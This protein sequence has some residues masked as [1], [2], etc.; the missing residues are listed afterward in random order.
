MNNPRLRP[1]YFGAA[2]LVAVWLLAWGGFRIAQNSK[3]TAAKFSAYLRAVDLEKLHGAAREQALRELADKLNALIPEERRRARVDREMD[4][5]FQQMTE[6]EK[7]KFIESTMPTGF[8]QMLTSFEKLPEDK[9]KKVID[10]TLKRFEDIRK[11][12]LPPGE[13]TNRPPPMSKELQKKVVTVGLSSF[14]S[15]SSAQTKAELAPV[16]EEMQRL[17]ESGQLFRRR[18]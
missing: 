13:G 5:W 2:A 6:E 17:M 11:G 12:E 18:E 15:Q 4:R 16:L 9:R 14:Y 10:D 8:K 3:I 1:L 7:G